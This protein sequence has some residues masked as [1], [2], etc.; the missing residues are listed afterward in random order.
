MIDLN[1]VVGNLCEN[2][3][4]HSPDGGAIRLKGGSQGDVSFLD[5]IDG[6]P[7]IPTV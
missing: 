3:L 7:V 4:R 2:A 6:G 5:I 1:Q